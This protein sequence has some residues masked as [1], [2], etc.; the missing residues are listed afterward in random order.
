MDQPFEWT[1]K[2]DGC[3]RFLMAWTD[4]GL[5]M[6]IERHMDRHY[7]EDVLAG[8]QS[9]AL[10]LYKRPNYETLLINTSD[11]GFLRTRHIKLDDDIIIDETLGYQASKTELSQQVWYKILG[12][13]MEDD[14]EQDAGT[15]PTE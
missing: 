11:A 8:I 4:K 7:Q 13:V 12:V 15:E 6:E 2:R 14:G 10:T 1:C 5:Q 3:K 9:T